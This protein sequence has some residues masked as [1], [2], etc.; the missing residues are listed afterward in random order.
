VPDVVPSHG[1]HLALVEPVIDVGPIHAAGLCFHHPEILSLE[2]TRQVMRRTVAH[3]IKMSL[4]DVVIPRGQVKVLRN[5]VMVIAVEPSHHVGGNELARIGIGPNHV[6]LAFLIAAPGVTDEAHPAQ[7]QAWVA[8]AHLD[9]YLVPVEVGLAPVRSR[10]ARV[11]VIEC[12][13]AVL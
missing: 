1:A 6:E 11:Q 2:A 8:I 7:Q 5:R 4:P 13:V 12:A 10:P 9:R 3:R